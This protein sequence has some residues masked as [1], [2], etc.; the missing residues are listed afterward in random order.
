M[1]SQICSS[2][3]KRVCRKNGIRAWPQRKVVKLGRAAQNVRPS[4][5][6]SCLANLSL[7][8]TPPD[9]DGGIL[10]ACHAMSRSEKFRLRLKKRD[11]LHLCGKIVSAVPFV[12]RRRDPPLLP[13]QLEPPGETWAC[14]SP[15]SPAAGC[16]LQQVAEVHSDLDARPSPAKPRRPHP[17]GGRR[18]VALPPPA[19]L[20]CGPI[21]L[22][23]RLHPPLPLIMV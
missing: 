2:T 22:T 18:C 17:V 5:S 9:S 20:L 4:V 19:S 21:G 10:I 12:S 13:V 3:L 14:A 6:F 15:C 16:R 23:V 1:I 11:T 7:P 8:S